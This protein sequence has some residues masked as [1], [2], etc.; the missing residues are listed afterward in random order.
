MEK[1]FNHY[2]SFK[3]EKEHSKAFQFINALQEKQQKNNELKKEKTINYIEKE[4]SKTMIIIDKLF[5]WLTYIFLKSS[6]FIIT[7]ITILF[8]NVSL[9]LQYIVLECMKYEKIDYKKQFTQS[10]TELDLAYCSLSFWEKEKVT[11]EKIMKRFDMTYYT[12]SRVKG[13]YRNKKRALHLVVNEEKI[14]NNEKEIE[15]DNVLN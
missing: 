3:K 6:L 13:L 9:A 7:N 12:A 14:N 2:V 10:F 1:L 8:N 11:I 4:K 15:I 5:Y